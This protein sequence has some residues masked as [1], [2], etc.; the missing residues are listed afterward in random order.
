MC[1]IESLKWVKCSAPYPALPCLGWCLY[2]FFHYMHYFLIILNLGW[3]HQTTDEPKKTMASTQVKTSTAPFSPLQYQKPKLQKKFML[4]LLHHHSQN[5]KIYK[6]IVQKPCFSTLH[7]TKNQNFM[8]CFSPWHEVLS[9]CET[10]K[11]QQNWTPS[12][13][14][15]LEMR[16]ESLEE[17]F[18]PQNL[19]SRK[20]KTTKFSE[21]ERLLLPNSWKEK[22]QKN[23]G[24][25]F[26]VCGFQNGRDKHQNANGKN[27][28]SN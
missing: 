5:K 14:P 25:W 28:P 17:T 16:L 20:K 26:R 4:S 18:L 9:I 11:R 6:T 12:H 13:W 10:R 7:E 23:S 19:H 8:N 3:T 1:N 15:H 27:Q 22:N 24:G 21:L 2:P